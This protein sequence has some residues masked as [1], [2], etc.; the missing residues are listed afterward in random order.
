MLL[1][2]F[3]WFME[4]PLPV[5]ALVFHLFFLLWFINSFYFNR[6]RLRSGV[7]F[8]LCLLSLAVFLFLADSTPGQIMTS[9]L[10]LLSA[11]L[12]LL[13]IF[14][15]I[16]LVVSML[17]NGVILLRKEGI[18]FHN[19]LSLIIVI[20]VIMT[21]V[22]IANYDKIIQHEAIEI[23]VGINGIL[24]IYLLL[25][26]VF[27]VTSGIL[28]IVTSQH[29]AV[30]YIIVL[31]CGLRKGKEVTPLLAGR[32]DRAIRLYRKAPQRSYLVMSGGQGDDEEISEAAAMKNYAL[33][34]GI[35]ENHIL[36]EENSVN[37]E[38]NMA[39]S[40]KLIESHCPFKCKISYATNRYHQFRAGAYAHDA[41][42]NI[43]GVGSRT[44]T[45]FEQNAIIREFLAM[46]HRDQKMH[47]IFL[48]ILV[49][50]YLY[51]VYSG[52]L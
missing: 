30:D 3:S 47:M 35:E 13:V 34:R 39:F 11:L 22:I 46:I 42:M 28:V 10:F 25:M 33:S 36:L 7:L 49:M 50:L 38:E 12:I 1:M 48:S 2:D 14:G 26:A 37:T 17:Y 41:G 20:H 51:T 5:A 15:G 32:V 40:K 27:Y 24:T 45:Y 21:P 31:G 4:N 8:F 44:K 19:C 23:L 9:V 18:S 43:R 16:L 52:V 29:R 6:Y